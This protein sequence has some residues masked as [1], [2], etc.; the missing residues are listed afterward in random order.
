MKKQ[1]R[2]KR[3]KVK[4]PRERCRDVIHVLESQLG[5]IFSISVAFS[6]PRF[7]ELP[8]EAWG[9]SAYLLSRHSC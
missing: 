3:T 7:M 2:E 4:E 8:F 5:P 9:V 6:P 1:T